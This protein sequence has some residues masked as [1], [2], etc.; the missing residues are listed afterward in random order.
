MFFQEDEYTRG[1]EKY[2]ETILQYER[3]IE[4]FYE[5]V[6][7]LKDAIMERTK[8][9]EGVKGE[10]DETKEKH[11]EQIERILK[12]VNILE[13]MNPSSAVHSSQ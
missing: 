8:E 5:Q 11:K 7:Q 13:D 4:N 12:E 3:K 9:M 1:L 2:K 6:K 10:L